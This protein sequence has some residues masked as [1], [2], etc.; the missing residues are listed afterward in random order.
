MKTTSNRKNKGEH[1]A[2]DSTFEHVFLVF[3]RPGRQEISL[4]TRLK[5]VQNSQKRQKI[6]FSIFSNQIFTLKTKSRKKSECMVFEENFLAFQNIESDFSHHLR[7]SRNRSMFRH[8][9]LAKKSR[10]SSFW[11]S[12]ESCKS[13]LG[14]R[15]SKNSMS[16]TF[17]PIYSSIRTF[18]AI[19]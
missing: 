5:F 1:T 19:L 14:A 13:L 17:H 8:H 16:P 9:F 11:S 10:F 3:L 4:K 15:I 6:E 12:L 18:F 7:F 2:L